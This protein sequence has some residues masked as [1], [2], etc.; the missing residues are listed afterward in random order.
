MVSVSQG[1][2]ADALFSNAP[3]LDT[4]FTRV[5][6]RIEVQN[7]GM[8]A[9]NY[10]ASRIRA[11]GLKSKQSYTD[12]WS[13]DDS[14]YCGSGLEADWRSYEDIPPGSSQTGNICFV[15]PK[16]DAGALLLVD[17]GGYRAGYED[18]RYWKL[19]E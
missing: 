16:F 14:N 4:D 7:D 3:E 5:A 9:D 12:W 11:F 15:V 13:F 10:D 17:D 2:R 1:N 18:W 19:R 8:R 6:V